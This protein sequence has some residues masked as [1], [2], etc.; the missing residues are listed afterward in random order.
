LQSD[1]IFILIILTEKVKMKPKYITKNEGIII[2]SDYCDFRYINKTCSDCK[3]ENLNPTFVYKFTSKGEIY[4][5]EKCNGNI[6][7]VVNSKK[8]EN[9]KESEDFINGK[10]ILSGGRWE[11]NK[12]KY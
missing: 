6:R 5:C 11:S 8:V 7:T 4:L 10:S 2:Y 9:L 12:K 1:I 3:G